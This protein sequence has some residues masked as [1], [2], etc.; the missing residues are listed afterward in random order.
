MDLAHDQEYLN[1]QERLSKKKK[2][3]SLRNTMAEIGF[4]VLAIGFFNVNYKILAYAWN[5][6]VYGT[7]VSDSIS[8]F[9]LIFGVI[10]LSYF[11]AKYLVII[12][13]KSW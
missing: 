7:G 13:K 2:A 12:I 3:D 10:P 6:Y 11:S 4:L 9:I 8:I 1:R 5:R